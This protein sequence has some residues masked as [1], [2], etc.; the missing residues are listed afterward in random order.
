MGQQKTLA[1]HVTIAGATYGPGDDVPDHIAEKIT[2]PKAWVPIDAD[3]P[4]EKPGNAGTSGG[5]RLSGAV[6]V[7]GRTYGPDDHIP[8]EVAAQITNPKACKGGKVP[9]ATKPRAAAAAKPAQP[10][11]PADKHDGDPPQPSSRVPEAPPK[12]G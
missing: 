9:A 11:K 12:G 6:S 1:R 2:N 3:E 8:D 7:G 10:A 5:A 4:V